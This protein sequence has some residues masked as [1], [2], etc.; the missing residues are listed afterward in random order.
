MHAAEPQRS[1]ADLGVPA[2]VKAKVAVVQDGVVAGVIECVLAHRCPAHRHI[3]GSK[4]R[5][6]LNMGSACLT[7]P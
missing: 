2:V 6:K 3:P 1:S 4:H 7:M 5:I